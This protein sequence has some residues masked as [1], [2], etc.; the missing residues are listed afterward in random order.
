MVTDM[1]QGP[2]I[3]FLRALNMMDT[4][5]TYREVPIP[6]PTSKTEQMAML[7]HEVIFRPPTLETGTG[8]SPKKT[9]GI[10]DLESYSA[11]LMGQS[12][13][14]IRNLDHKDMIATLFRKVSLGA[15]WH[16]LH[17]EM[18]AYWR[19]DPPILYPRANLYFGVL[20]SG[21]AAAANFA[22]RIG[23]TLQRVSKED[24]IAALVE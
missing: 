12:Q 8:K 9:P 22:I 23:Y 4:P 1:V 24:F 7:I 17:E 19:F 6:C 11:Q 18:P 2:F 20:T 3:E 21:F 16:W 13:G 5:N 15:V 14:G 10:A